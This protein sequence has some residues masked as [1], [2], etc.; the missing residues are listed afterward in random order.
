MQLIFATELSTSTRKEIMLKNKYMWCKIVVD[1]C[2]S[3]PVWALSYHQRIFISWLFTLMSKDWLHVRMKLELCLND[4][5]IRFTNPTFWL[6]QEMKSVPFISLSFNLSTF[7]LFSCSL[8]Q[9]ATY[10][11]STKC[12]VRYP[13]KKKSILHD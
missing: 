3:R 12:E 6:S 9:T 4:V 8:L 2:L 11:T 1:L 5:S 13:R 7:R 10:I